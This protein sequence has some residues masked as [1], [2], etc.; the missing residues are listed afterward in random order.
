MRKN[1]ILRLLNQI[2][3]NNNYVVLVFALLITSSAWSFFLTSATTM[4]IAA[5]AILNFWLERKKNITLTRFKWKNYFPHTCVSALFFLTAISGL[6]SENLMD[7]FTAIRVKAPLFVL[8]ISIFFLPKLTLKQFY[9]IFTILIIF[10]GCYSLYIIIDYCFH[11]KIYIDLLY[12]GQ[13]VPHIRDHVRFT[14]L[15]AFAFVIGLVILEKNSLQLIEKRIYYV[16]LAFIFIGL[17]IISARSGLL[18]LYASMLVYFIRLAFMRKQYFRYMAFILV[19]AA[20]PIIAFYSIESFHQKINYVI[21]DKQMQA[22]GNSKTYSDGERWISNDIGLK[23]F[24]ENKIIGTGAGDFWSELQKKYAVSNPNYEV[25]MPHNQFI[26]VA[27][28]FG[29]LGLLVFL[30]AFLFNASQ[31]LNTVNDFK[32]F[33]YLNMFLAFCFDVPLEAEFGI[34]F[35]AFFAS[36]LIKQGNG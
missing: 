24:Y 21:W 1:S 31:N 9:Q 17:H 35:Y 5:L 26:V 18:I 34:V 15:C 28:S 19:V 8:P 14:I 20:V 11:S 32:L 2:C 13:P 6:W 25:K 30:C 22:Q 3:S 4:L 7:Y 27:A 23:I 36:L 33:F 10:L 12:L 29:I 16:A